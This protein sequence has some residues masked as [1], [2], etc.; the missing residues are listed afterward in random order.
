MSSGSNSEAHVTVFTKLATEFDPS[1][2]LS[3]RLSLTESGQVFSDGSAC[4]M[5]EGLAKRMAV[6]NAATFR[7]LINGLESNNALALGSIVH[8]E[9]RVVTTAALA[10]LKGGN[11]AVPTIARNREHV[12]YRDGPGWALID[13]DYKWVTEFTRARIE[14]EGGFWDI[15]L[16]VAPGLAQAA[17]VTRASTSAGLRREDTGE[18]IP[19]S[20][21]EHH[22]ILVR[23]ATDI[24]RAMLALQDRCWLSNLSWF[25]VGAAGQV[26]ERS[27]LDVSVRFGERLSFEG[28]PEVPPPLVQNKMVR[29]AAAYEGIAIDTLVVLPGLSAYEQTRLEEIK[30]RAYAEIE[31]RA[32]LIRNEADR[33]L[34][35][36]I[37]KESGMPFE[38]ALRKAAARHR[39]MLSPELVLDFDNFGFVTVKGVLANPDK[40]IDE[41]LADPLEGEAYGRD[42]ARVFRA[43]SDPNDLIIHSFAHCGAVYHL[44]HDAS[45]INAAIDVVDAKYAVDILCDRVA[46]A[47]LNPDELT[48]LIAKAAKKKGVGVR[49]VQARIKTERMKR[50][51]AAHAAEH[52]RAS[53]ADTRLTRLLPFPDGELRPVIELV[54]EVLA[55]DTSEEPPTRDANGAFVEVRTVEPWGLHTL[56][57]TGANADVSDNPED[58]LP[59]PPEPML[60]Q[61]SKVEVS[62]L[63]ERYVRYVTPPTEKSAGHE[64]RLQA[65]YIEALMALGIAR[66]KMPE[67]RA[68]VTAPMVAMGG[69]LISGVGLD[70]S[71][72]IIYR[73]DPRLLACLPTDD[74]LVED[75]VKEQL[76]WLLNEWLVDV[77]AGTPDKLTMVSNAITK[78]QRVLLPERPAFF[79]TAYQRGGGKTTTIRMINAAVFGRQTAAAAWS[80]SEEERRKALFSYLL[81]SVATICW[82]NIPRGSQ[83]TSAAIE[84]ALTI[85]ETSDRILGVNK[86]A[87]PRTSTVMDFTG[88][89]IAPKGDMASRSLIISILVS[90]PDPENRSFRHPDIIGWTLQN[91]ARVLR[92]IYTILVYGCRNRPAGQELKTRFKTWWGLCGWPVELAASLIGEKLDFTKLFAA[93][94]SEDVET[95]AASIALS[96]LLKQ[97]PDKREF[98][99]KSI[100]EA[101]E[102]GTPTFGRTIAPGAQDTANSLLDVL[103]EMAGK[104]LIRPTPGTIG[105]LL[106][107]QLVGRP[108]FI[109][110][111]KIVAVLKVRSEK[112]LNYY[113]AELLPDADGN[114]VSTDSEPAVNTPTSPTS[115]T[116]D[117]DSGWTSWTSWTDFGRSEVQEQVISPELAQEEPGANYMSRDSAPA[118]IS[119]PSTPSPPD[120]PA[121]SVSAGTGGTGGT[122]NGHSEVSVKVICSDGSLVVPPDG[123]HPSPDREPAGNTPT[124][125]AV[126]PNGEDPDTD[127]GEVE[128]LVVKTW[129]DDPSQSN[130]KIAR[131]CGITAKR[132]KEIL[133]AHV[134]TLR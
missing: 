99:A 8:E 53:L 29:A 74:D 78:V 18:D 13:C 101:I 33:Q 123:K 126:P 66:S 120:T 83:V 104:R 90:R 44:R 121:L 81:Q 54:D 103:G 93:S 77:S 39:G 119:T 102:A 79:F 64:A 73:I 100:A 30:Q 20:G 4:R 118:V 68:I 2:L 87:A 70:A 60:V 3:K 48:E 51:Q 80:D 11:S 134:R 71:S 107:N 41:T 9:A 35:E 1:T 25:A 59:A 6:P 129:H 26:F 31:P 91:R 97:Y 7:E 82:D 34:A 55:A 10:R 62:L 125:P 94:E 17:R 5:S 114:H 36:K 37:S 133:A 95:S 106:K 128:K 43:R 92:A 12:D 15:L 49:S 19:W 45:T 89:A 98:T 130:A 132:V 122:V 96:V 24:N 69:Q 124:S 23:D 85:S 61:L 108:T 27:L 28:P 16:S 22:Y 67:V 50:E 46:I 75:N 84:K 72:K 86:Y 42:K 57:A 58:I 47:D 76:R 38:V 109:D 115:P 21:G 52:T 116:K 111:P 110:D 40:Y 65:P 105:M 56:T 131:A 32:A 14:A 113:H 112:S 127:L 88:N 63:V 117:S